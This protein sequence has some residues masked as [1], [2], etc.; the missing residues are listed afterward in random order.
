[1]LTLTL[2]HPTIPLIT[3]TVDQRVTIEFL[4]G[5]TAVS[6]ENQ[7]YRGDESEKKIVAMIVTCF[8]TFL[9]SRNT[10]ERIDS[11]CPLAG[12][13]RA[14]NSSPDL[15]D[16]LLLQNLNLIV[17]VLQDILQYVRTVLAKDRRRRKNLRRRFGKIN[18]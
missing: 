4:R 2:F 8:M 11:C 6:R 12:N 18:G 15:D 10:V 1:M 16:L 13:D 9:L 3:G 7:D 14:S 5:D 17:G